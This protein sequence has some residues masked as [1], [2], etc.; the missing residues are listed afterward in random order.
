MA[1]E[2]LQLEQLDRL[3][4]HGW[5]L[6]FKNLLSKENR[7]WWRSKRWLLQAALWTFFLNG[8]LIMILFIL[9]AM[10]TPDGQ[11]VL[12]GDT[13][14]SGIQGY[15]SL[16]S[17]A[18][19]LGITILVQDT[20]IGEKQSG[21]AEWVLSKPASR[22]AF[23][24]SKLFSNTLAMLVVMVAIP[25]IIAYGLLWIFDGNFYPVGPF[26][27][28]TAT[29]F[30]HIFFY[31]SLTLMAG[32]LVNNR[33]TVLAISLGSLLGG[34]FL[35]NLIP[36]GLSLA[37]PW[38]LPDIT[39]LIAMGEPLPPMLWIPMITTAIWA[40]IFVFVALWKFQKYEF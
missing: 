18:L 15:F 22:S 35:R 33:S 29:I 11:S 37:T 14:Q 24:L 9:P 40:L 20:V 8:L 32:I 30:L 7:R 10:V 34:S 17:I 25:G 19:A 39:A 28:G 2:T 31:L 12:P 16:A 38:L 13:L 27:A 23:I 21:T 4:D 36:P 6:G 3:K 26:L 1:R 5:R